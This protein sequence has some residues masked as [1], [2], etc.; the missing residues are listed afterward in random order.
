[1]AV[2][3]TVLYLIF[4]EQF[5]SVRGFVIGPFDFSFFSKFFKKEEYESVST[6]PQPSS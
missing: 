5:G 3:L 2:Y 4:E 6:I 1:M